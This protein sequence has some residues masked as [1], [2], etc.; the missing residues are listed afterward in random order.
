[1]S[2]QFNEDVRIDGELYRQDPDTVENLNERHVPCII[3]LDVSG[4]MCD[5]NAIDLLNE[6]IKSFKEQTLAYDARKSTIIDVSVVSFG[7]NGV[8][9]VQNFKPIRDMSTPI[10]SA[11]GGTPLGE[12]IDFSLRLMR[13]RKNLY[14]Q[15]KCNDLRG[16][17]FCITDGMPTD[18]SSIWSSA[19][20]DLHTAVNERSVIAL[21]TAVGEFQTDKMI[22]MFGEKSCLRLAGLDFTDYF[23]FVS[24]SIGK[25]SDSAR[26]GTDKVGIDETPK[27]R[28]FD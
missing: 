3:M 18:D 19:V 10:L 7:G 6:G 11:N 25:I 12:A 27:T 4:S 21:C 15:K 9:L 23:Q 8:Q 1:M 16:W 13:E 20:Q 26:I 22:E 17:I 5:N 2:N 28:F 14:R 24:N